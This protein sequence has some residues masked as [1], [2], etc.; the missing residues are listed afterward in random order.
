[1]RAEAI[2]AS[3]LGVCRTVTTVQYTVYSTGL[4]L[5]IHCCTQMS[6]SSEWEIDLHTG[7]MSTFWSGHYLQCNQTVS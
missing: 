3:D 1:M 4:E 5:M 6:S 7:H 2:Y